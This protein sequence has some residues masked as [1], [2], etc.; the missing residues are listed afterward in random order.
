M[1]LGFVNAAFVQLSIW[2]LYTSVW[3]NNNTQI[4]QKID[5]ND[6]INFNSNLSILIEIPLDANRMMISMRLDNRMTTTLRPLPINFIKKN[7]RYLK[8]RHFWKLFFVKVKCSF[9]RLQITD[10]KKR[11]LCSFLTKISN[12]W[13]FPVWRG[14]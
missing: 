8:K 5:W 6:Q 2:F 4:N 9:K 11:T 13:V 3:G 14:P 10:S 7:L 12:H 1:T